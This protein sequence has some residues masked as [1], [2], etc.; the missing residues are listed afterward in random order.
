MFNVGQVEVKLIQSFCISI[1][2]HKPFNCSQH[3]KQLFSRHLDKIFFGNLSTGNTFLVFLHNSKQCKVVYQLPIFQLVSESGLGVE[4]NTSDITDFETYTSLKMSPSNKSLP[5]T[6]QTNKQT[7]EDSR[8]QRGNA[9]HHQWRSKYPAWAQSWSWSWWSWHTWKMTSNCSTWL[10][11]RKCA[12]KMRK[13]WK[14]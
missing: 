12:G 14:L 4:L 11:T 10:S 7:A 13:W 1:I 2:M 9:R 5:A 8:R 6:K 3:F